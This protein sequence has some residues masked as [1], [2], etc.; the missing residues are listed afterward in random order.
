MAKEDGE[1]PGMWQPKAG[2]KEGVPGGAA[3]LGEQPL[4]QPPR[5]V[6]DRDP[7]E[8]AASQCVGAPG[9]PLPGETLL[10]G[11]GPPRRG[12]AGWGLG[13]CCLQT[14]S[15]WRRRH[16][17]VGVLRRVAQPSRAL[18]GGPKGARGGWG[19]AGSLSAVFVGW[20]PRAFAG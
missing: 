8:T 17:D 7:R 9:C 4:P 5:K 13:S 11:R 2:D 1:R 10:Q 19:T 18:D 14:S 3:G 16:G 15:V 20:A 6:V 12:T